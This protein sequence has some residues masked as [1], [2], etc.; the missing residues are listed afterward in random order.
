MGYTITVITAVVSI[1]VKHPEGTTPEVT[2]FEDV[3][4]DCGEVDTE[5]YDDAGEPVVNVLETTVVSQDTTAHTTDR[6]DAPA[7]DA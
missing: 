6:P 3:H 1:T 5:D 7:P 4:V 2:G